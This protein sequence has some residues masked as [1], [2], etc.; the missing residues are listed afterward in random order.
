MRNY[1]CPEAG[2][3]CSYLFIISSQAPERS[4]AAGAAS[5]KGLADALFRNESWLHIAAG[6]TCGLVR[7]PGHSY[8][9]RSRVW[10]RRLE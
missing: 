10:G 8:R 7:S 6:C 2:P 5:G 1:S 3:L 9:W 4:P